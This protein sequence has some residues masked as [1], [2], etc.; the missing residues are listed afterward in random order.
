MRVWTVVGEV[1]EGEAAGSGGRNG[2]ALLAG[3]GLQWGWIGG[4]RQHA[5]P[6]SGPCARGRRGGRWRRTGSATR[7]KQQGLS[8]VSEGNAFAPCCAHF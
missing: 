6:L 1:G 8:R 7:H 5:V 2:A 3:G 4:R